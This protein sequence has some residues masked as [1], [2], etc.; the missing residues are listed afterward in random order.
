MTLPDQD[1]LM[2]LSSENRVALVHRVLVPHEDY[3][4]EYAILITDK[5]SLFIRQKKTRSSF[6]LRGE[7]RYGT[8]LVTDVVPESLEKYA[9]PS[10]ESLSENPENLTIFHDLV[11][12]LTLK[13]DAP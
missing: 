11:R 3:P 5:R 1:E 12:S 10:L 2:S 13:K 6:V 4:R 8:A 7:M 9:Q